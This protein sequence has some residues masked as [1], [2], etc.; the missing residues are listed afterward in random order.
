MN[1]IENHIDKSHRGQVVSSVL[2]KKRVNGVKIT[3]VWLAE[4]LKID[5]RTLINW[6]A[7]PDLSIENIRQIGRVIKHDFS[8]E[9]PEY[10]E[11]LVWTL[12]EEAALMDTPDLREQID[13]IK[14]DRDRYKDQYISL[15]E[16]YN[17]LQEEFYNLKLAS[18]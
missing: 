14:L 7:K 3:Q 5:R 2:L 9:F 4:R 13:R 15:L 16:R 6:L 12:A 8:N 11:E 18:K 1:S 17:K 10:R